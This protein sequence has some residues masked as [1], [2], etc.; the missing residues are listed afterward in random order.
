[1]EFGT[2]FSLGLYFVVMLGIGLYAYKKSTSDVS[3]YMLGGRNLSPSVTALSA[4]ASD[5]SGW[6]LMGLPGAMYLSG[7]SSAWIGIGLII[8]AY[9]N[10]L[11]VAP[12][13]R[14]YTELA[15]DSITLP[16]FFE[17]RFN[18]DKRILRVISSLVIIIFFTLYTSSGVV[19]GGKL[20]ES[21]FGMSYELGLYVTAGVVVVYTLFGGFLAVSLTDFVQGC[22]M[23]LALVLVPIVVL[24][25]V[26]GLSNAVTTV[27]QLNPSL[28][29][30]VSGVSVLGVIS[31]MAWGLGYFGQP[32]IIVRFMAIRSVKD[33]PIARRIGMSWMI[34]SLIGALATGFVGVVYVNQTG[35]ELKDA[36][37]IFILL[38]QVLFHPLI[39]G[40]LLAAIL[41]AIM[42][43]ISSQL[44][45]T[46]SSLTEDIYKAFFNQQ[47]SQTTLV[48][49]GRI[50]VLVVALLAIFL[51]YDRDS[52][53]LS[54]VSNA[55]AGFGA[56][57]GPVVI[58]SLYWSRM[59]KQGALAG[60]I[61]GAATVLLWI[62]LPITVNGESLSSLMY[63][64]VPGFVIASIAIV[65]V[66]KLSNEPSEEQIALFNQVRNSQYKTATSL[67]DYWA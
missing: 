43:T 56:A 36:E 6:M 66:S 30:F 17:N 27:E 63:E 14:S 26:G 37:T 12:R 42:S 13:L 32:H 22:I 29:S 25:E 31:A 64:I 33:L 28:L 47:A 18:D 57:F 3:G 67:K 54:L 10:Y 16:D 4:G 62:Y 21:S 15:N 34:V 44:L 1:M 19:A 20:F 58:L 46:S 24:T 59:T 2:I 60:I 11:I 41:A 65:V 49:V 7:L 48:M 38:S 52:S 40:F 55:W 61:S 35:T 5:M 50:S 9:L 23:F 53:I 45:V 51:A 8:G 39:A